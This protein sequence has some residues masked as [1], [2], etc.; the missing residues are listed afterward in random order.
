MN[1]GIAYSACVMIRPI[2]L[3]VQ[4]T[5]YHHAELKTCH[6]FLTDVPDKP[7]SLEVTD[8]QKNSVTLQWKPPKNDGGSPITGY[9]LEK[10]DTKRATW[11]SAGKAPKDATELTVDKVNEGTEY[12]FRVMAENKKGQSQPCETQSSVV[13]KSPHGRCTNMFLVE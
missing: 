7:E 5:M 10:R 6:F 3:Y 8:I 11:T 9:I 13:V 1:A 2:W 12:M 4:I